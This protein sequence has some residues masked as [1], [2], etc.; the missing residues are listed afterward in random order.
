MSA[1]VTAAMAAASAASA[2]AATAGNVSK[3]AADHPIFLIV[4]WAQIIVFTYLIIRMLYEEY[5]DKKGR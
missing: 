4:T 2:S 3:D 5:K 1:A